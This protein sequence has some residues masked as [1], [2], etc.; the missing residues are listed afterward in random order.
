MA[1]H[2]MGVHAAR[3]LDLRRFER[4]LRQAVS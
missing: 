2:A 1:H 3:A 4:A